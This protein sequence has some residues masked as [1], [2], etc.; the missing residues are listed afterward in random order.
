MTESGIGV[1]KWGQME[2]WVL[3]RMGHPLIPCWGSCILPL[4]T[5]IQI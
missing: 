4:C 3:K 5:A 2:E 1:T